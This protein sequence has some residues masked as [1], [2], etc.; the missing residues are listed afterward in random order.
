MQLRVTENQVK[1]Q[2]KNPRSRQISYRL[3]GEDG[4]PVQDFS[5]STIAPKLITASVKGKA[6]GIRVKSSG[7]FQSTDIQSDNR[8]QIFDQI[9]AA[10]TKTP[11]TVFGMQV[12][13]LADAKVAEAELA[14]LDLELE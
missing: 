2:S 5:P 13:D 1:T 14:S 11:G 7:S 4:K 3:I 6:L 9:W 8:G 12:T 10:C